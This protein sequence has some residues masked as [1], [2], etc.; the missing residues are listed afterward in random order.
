MI[1]SQ[2]H[3][4]SEKVQGDLPQCSHTKR[5][6]SQE[7]LSDRESISSGHQSVQGKGEAFFRFSDAEEAAGVALEEQRDNLLAEAKSEILKQEC[8]VDTLNTCFRQF[9]RQTR[10]NRWKM[11][12]VNCGHEESRREQARLYEAL[13]LREKALQD[14]RIRN[15][16]EV[17][18]LERA[19]EMR[20]DEFSRN[21]L[22]ESHATILSSQYLALVTNM[23]SVVLVL[24]SSCCFPLL[25]SLLLILSRRRRLLLLIPPSSLFHPP[26]SSLLLLLLLRPPSFL[27]P[28]S[29]LPHPSLPLSSLLFPPSCNTT[30][31]LRHTLELPFSP[32]SLTL[33]KPSLRLPPPACCPA[34]LPPPL[35]SS[36]FPFTLPGATS[37]CDTLPKESQGS[38]VA[39]S[40][41]TI[42]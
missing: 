16:H 12:S 7:T 20:I 21:E 10:S 4:T 36:I 11:D 27:S 22:R 1:R 39:S 38:F 42:K 25:F 28:F 35:P 18:E 31:F 14:T 17:E 37:S 32:C 29:N 6:S 26:S 13:P 41:H 8:K 5:K 30:L 23:F 2:V 40:R 24:C 9:Q 34:S 3:L 33:P 15:I 19:Q